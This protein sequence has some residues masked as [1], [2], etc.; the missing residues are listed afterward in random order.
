[1]ARR[2]TETTHLRAILVWL[3]GIGPN[4]KPIV[5]QR[6]RYRLNAFASTEMPF[7]L[8]AKV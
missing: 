7:G 4:R 3:L 6:Q 8:P 5:D 1:M 2:Q